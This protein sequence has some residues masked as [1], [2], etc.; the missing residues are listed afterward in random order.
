MKLKF[1]KALYS[2]FFLVETG[3][4]VRA[5]VEQ[6]QDELIRAKLKPAGEKAAAPA[7]TVAQQDAG[8]ALLRDPKLIERIVADVE[9]TGV[10]G[11]AS[12]ALVAYLACVSRKLDKPLAMP[13]RIDH[14]HGEHEVVER[15]RGGLA[16]GGG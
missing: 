15:G 16:G 12:N 11:E 6:R 13:Q 1:V 7:L 14:I 8:L 5:P 4:H 3:I 2:R 9:A 10:V